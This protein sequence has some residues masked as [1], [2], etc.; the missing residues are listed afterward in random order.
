VNRRTLATAAALTAS[1]ALLAACGGGAAA[2]DGDGASTARDNATP[3]PTPI[4]RSHLSGRAEP[5]GR[6]LVVKL[7]NS[8]A[9]LPHTGLTSA[10]L[11][12][13]Q[14]VEG[15][16]S[17]LAAVYSTRLPDQIAP[18][19][20]ARE[21]DAQLLPQLGAV[22]VGFSGSIR[23]VHQQV[24]NAGLIDVSADVGPKGY[25]RVGWRSAPHDLAA[26]PAALLERAP[27]SPKARDMGWTFGA[28]P[29]GGS[30]ARTVTATM[31]AAR[32]SFT[33]SAK[34]G[35]YAVALDGIPDRTKAEGQVAR[36]R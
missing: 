29:K 1:A 27:G 25:S 24:T 32:V 8:R 15:G 35:R 9:A 2:L 6:V 17:R 36:A 12:Y 4:E 22:P 30:P 34:T 18:V 13:V 14:Q 5:D 16:I 19:R 26:D 21:T 23:T 20:S 11:V 3:T 10:D 28:T 33:Y 31:P 7:D